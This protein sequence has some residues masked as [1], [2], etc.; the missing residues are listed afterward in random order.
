MP[1]RPKKTP[2]AAPATPVRARAPA[3]IPQKPKKL[4]LAD[5]VIMFIETHCRVPDGMNMGQPMKLEPFQKKFLRK[6]WDN[7]A[8]TRL[9]IFSSGRKNA[10]TALIAMIVLACLVGPIAV[11]NSEIES[12]AMSRDQASKVFKYCVKIIRLSPELSGMIHVIPSSKTLMGLRMNTTYTALSADAQTAHGGSPRVAIMDELGQVK[13]PQSEFFDAIET[14]QGAHNEPL[15]II[16]STQAATDGDLLSILIDDAEI[17]GDPQIICDLYTAPKNCDL[18]DRK[19]WEAA[20]PAMGK[21][22]TVSS[23]QKQA[24]KAVRM[25]SSA[26]K[27]RNLILNQRVVTKDPFISRDTWMACAATAERPMVPLSKCTMIYGGLDLSGRLDLTAYV[28]LG[29]YEGIWYVYPFFWT[30]ED[31]LVD[32]SKRDRAPYDVWVEQGHIKTTPGASIKYEFVAKNIGEINGELTVEGIAYD[33]WRMDI[34][35]KELEA[36]GLELPLK[37]WGQGFKDM[38]PSLDAIEEMIVNKTLRHGDHPVLNAC[39]ANAVVVKDPADN[40]KL[41]KKKATG[42]IDGA[43]AGAMAAGMAVRTMDTEGPLDD[44]IQNPVIA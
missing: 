41:D 23:I 32:R 35:K 18:M 4:S 36:I 1:A 22:L 9:A 16:I 20:N 19:A 27:F 25:P 7:P 29:Y 33:R 14:S 6:I 39:M 5:K 24:E 8:G 10:K 15:L 11:E 31:G 37:E 2:K 42:R 43:V 21:F 34:L 26:G 30:P 28:L 44:F 38:A 3:R 13:G 40:R 17:A 12:G